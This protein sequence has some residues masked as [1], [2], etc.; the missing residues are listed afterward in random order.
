MR[1]MM[2]YRHYFSAY[3]ISNL[4]LSI[5]FLFVRL[6]KPF[7]TI[8]PENEESK[9]CQLSWNE[10]NILL[11]LACTIA[12]KNRKKPPL[13][14]LLTKV[15]LFCK[16]ANTLLFGLTDP[17]LSILFVAVAVGC[18][19]VFPEPAYVGP[20]N[21]VYFKGDSL[22]EELKANPRTT[23]VVEFMATWSASCHTFAPTFAK[24][25]MEYSHNHLK[26]GKFDVGRY[27]EIAE[28]FQVDSS[29]ISKQLPTIVLFQGG[30]EI[31]RKPGRN[32]S[33][34]TV[35]YQFTKENVVR[36]FNLDSLYQS[37]KSKAQRKADKLEAKTQEQE[38]KDN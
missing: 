7:C 17:R 35:K 38:K 9:E 5:S 4:I 1:Q 16:V 27:P 6:V 26:F 25:S 10:S 11:F 34:Q 19:V 12:V 33:G 22:E 23:W 29:S 31:M 18:M 20:Q 14:E 15:F 37:T 13:K 21:I 36:D 24:L 32:S 8:F 30:K 28:I 2:Q 3:H